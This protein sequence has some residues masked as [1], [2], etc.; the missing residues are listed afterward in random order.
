MGG[1]DDSL[2]RSLSGINSDIYE[3]LENIA[4]QHTEIFPILIGLSFLTFLEGIIGDDT[5]TDLLIR[6]S[7]FSLDIILDG[8]INIILH[9]SL[10]SF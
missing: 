2:R 8:F 3:L 4:N 6:A 1:E 9:L 5:N 10:F 7:F